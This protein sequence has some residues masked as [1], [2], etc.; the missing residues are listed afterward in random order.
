MDRPRHEQGFSLVELLV[1]IGIIA[2]LMGT[3]LP[4]LGRA[5][6]SARETQC[7][8]NLRQWG[9]GFEMY[10][11]QSKGV[12]P[13][14]GEDGNTPTSADLINYWDAPWMWFNA[15]PRMLSRKSYDELQQDERAGAGR[16][17]IDGDNS[18][19]VCPSASRAL[20]VGNDQVYPDGYFKMFG[21]V[22]SPPATAQERK[23]FLCYVMNSKLVDQLKNPTVKLSRLRP[24]SVYVLMVEKRM[25]QGELSK[26]NK[27]AN[28]TAALARI[29]SDR[30]RF[31]ARHRNGGFLLFADGHVAFFTNAEVNTRRQTSPFADYNWPNKLMWN[32]YGHAD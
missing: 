9:M 1:V 4:A 27:D 15:I 21:N 32:P 13:R 25:R 16:L 12:L 28:W 11:N 6:E 23:T 20:G 7:M 2:L 30:K 31:A 14:D 17:P 10:C 26:G 29:K 3:L 8:N 24:A 19:F 18:L 5:R 22:L